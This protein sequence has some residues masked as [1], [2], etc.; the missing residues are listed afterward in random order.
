MTLLGRD[1]PE[2]SPDVLFSRLEIRALRAFAARQRH[3]PP[4]TL[5]GA[6][7]TKAR[8]GGHI[9][10]SRGP[11]P[12]TRVIWRGYATLAEWCIGYELM[13]GQGT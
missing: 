8:I 7:L 6:V 13:L 9:H 11:P 10:R 4:D 5:A 12:G 1:H 3:A 2:L